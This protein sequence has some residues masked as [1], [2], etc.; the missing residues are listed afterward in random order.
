[1]CGHLH[2]GGPAVRL[3]PCPNGW[4]MQ[5]HMSLDDET[6]RQPGIDPS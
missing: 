1:M 3:R 4:Q 5:P 2:A 6:G